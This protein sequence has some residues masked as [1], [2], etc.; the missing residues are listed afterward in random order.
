[1]NIIT[2]YKLAEI[3]DII[4]HP[5]IDI[6][7]E[8][9]D[10]GVV[11][12]YS[13]DEHIDKCM[14]ALSKDGKYI[15]LLKDSDNIPKQNILDK[16]P[17]VKYWFIQNCHIKSDIVEATPGGIFICNKQGTDN[18]VELIEATLKTKRDIRSDI[19]GCFSINPDRADIEPNRTAA[20]NSIIGKP[21][22]TWSEPCGRNEFIDG[23]YRHVFT[24]SPKGAGEDCHRTWEA[25]YL[26]SYPIVKKCETYDNFTD[27]P[28][29]MLNDWSEITPEWLSEQEVVM[30]EK[31][32]RRLDLDYLINRIQTE[33]E[34][35][36]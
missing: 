33:K 7:F 8:P 19:F 30:K 36:I 13:M 10:S 32:T 3:C 1:M 23:I 24:L 15:C 21:Y 20:K 11:L 35:L 22:A 28:I 27:M 29:A 18:H 2:P 6:A 25:L 34:R 12:C 16:Y 4:Y 17:Q 26:G 31:T 9:K 5:Y 14:G